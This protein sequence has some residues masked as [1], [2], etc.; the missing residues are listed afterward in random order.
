MSFALGRF[1]DRDTPFTGAV[2]D[3]RVW[4]VFDLL[5]GWQE[6]GIEALF[7]DWDGIVG[8]ISTALGDGWRDG[9]KMESEL[10]RIA[11]V[12]PRQV[13]CAGMNYRTHV[14]DLMVDQGVGSR[15]GMSAEEIRAEAAEVMDDR[16]RS[17]TPLVFAGLPSSV[18]G[19]DD[20]VELRADSSQTDWE[21]ELAAVIGREGRNI[22]VEDALS[23]VAGWTVANDITARDY[24]RRSDAGA[25]NVDWLRAKCAPTYTP[26]GPYV[27]P[28]AF[29][30]DPQDLRITLRLNGDTMQDESTADMIFDVA[31]L[32][33][34]LS[35]EV[36]LLPGDLLLTG[37]PAGNGSHYGRFLR[38]GDLLE[39]Q[40]EGLGIQRNRCVGGP[41]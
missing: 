20:E 35:R 10:R 5:P 29:V 39:G 7:A 11:P 2:V 15:P 16:A 27:V 31:S 24:V 4:P 19:P 13:F 38:A 33:A 18:C 23:H 30:P 6:G 36:K 9:F 8:A 3:G 34:Y 22:P 25:V 14:I 41:V 1:S 26:V 12:A 37:S 28:A 40:I 32:L 17:G 21:L